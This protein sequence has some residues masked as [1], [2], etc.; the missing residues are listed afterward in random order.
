[1]KQ[2]GNKIPL[3][4]HH[5]TFVTR[6]LIRNVITMG[7]GERGAVILRTDKLP[8]TKIKT[9]LQQFDRTTQE[10]QYALNLTNNSNSISSQPPFMT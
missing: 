3:H 10:F 1:M 9:K 4:I 5:F 6:T 8:N 2:E 7:K